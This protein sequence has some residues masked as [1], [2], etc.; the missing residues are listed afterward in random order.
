MEKQE[1]KLID[2]TALRLVSILYPLHQWDEA[3]ENWTIMCL[4]AIMR[5]DEGQAILIIPG[6]EGVSVDRNHRPEA[7][8]NWGLN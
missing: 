4:A 2:D 6:R 1:M 3:I 5:G 8:D 7:R